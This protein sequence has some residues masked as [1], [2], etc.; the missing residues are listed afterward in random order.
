MPQEGGKTPSIYQSYPV[1]NDAQLFSYLDHDATV[2]ARSVF[3]TAQCI[4]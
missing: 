2:P 1:L 3:V 4:D